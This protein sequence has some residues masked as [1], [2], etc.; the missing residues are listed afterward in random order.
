MSFDYGTGWDQAYVSKKD[1]Q[2]SQ[3]KTVR[4]FKKAVQ[5]YIQAR[6]KIHNTASIFD[7]KRYNK[8]KNRELKK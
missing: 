1:L 5:K 2:S 3:A 4:R 8:L 7:L 6:I